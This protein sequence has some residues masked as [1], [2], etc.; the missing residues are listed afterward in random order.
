MARRWRDHAATANYVRVPERTSKRQIEGPRPR[1]LVG[2]VPAAQLEM[3][4]KEHWPVRYEEGLHV[5]YRGFDARGIEPQFP[6]GHG[7]SYTTFALENAKLSSTRVSA[8]QVFAVSVTVRNT[9]SRPGAEVVQVYVSDTQSAL[10]R[11]PQELKGFAKVAL[12]PGESREVRIELGEEALRYYDP[13]RGTWVAEPGAFS[14]LVGTSSRAIAAT[15]R[16]EYAG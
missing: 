15:L 8:G 3:M 9:G 4:R 2:K 6:F 5:G 13:G 11:P 7:L 1:T 16:L 10:P 12:E 14:I